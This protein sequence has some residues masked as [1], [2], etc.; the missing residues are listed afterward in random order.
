MASKKQTNKFDIKTAG[1]M[2]YL[3]VA[4]MM[5]A[6]TLFLAFSDQGIEASNSQ[7]TPMQTPTILP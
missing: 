4:V 3:S 6:L 5:V 7:V 1:L 2:L